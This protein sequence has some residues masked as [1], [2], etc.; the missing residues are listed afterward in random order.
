MMKRRLL[1]I[2]MGSLI[3]LAV[4]FLAAWQISRVT[5]SPLV[6]GSTSGS[7]QVGGPFTL[8]DHTGA[9]VTERDFAGRYLLVYFGY[10]FCP[11]VCPTDLQVLAQTM[12][13]L[14]PDADLVQP[15]FVTIDP[16]RDTPEALAGYV[17]LFHPRLVGLTGTPEQVAQ[18]ASAYKVYYAKAGDD[19]DY[20]LMDHSSFIY[21]MG[22]DGKF[23]D[24]FPRGAAPERIAEKVRERAGR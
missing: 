21:L 7:A 11:D 23:L 10:S 18:A 19:P 16:A 5:Q 8:V 13:H 15:L 1:R 2:A 24:V 12:D 9:T 6:A 22:P 4:A 3:G 20:Y 17:G 14:G